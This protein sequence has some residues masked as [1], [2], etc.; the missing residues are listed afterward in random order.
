MTAKQD[1][2]GYFFGR[3]RQLR[4]NNTVATY[5]AEGHKMYLALGRIALRQVD[6]DVPS[7]VPVAGREADQ[8][9]KR[10]Y[11]VEQTVHF[12]VLHRN[13]TKIL[14]G[15]VTALVTVIVTQKR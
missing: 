14:A 8:H 2:Y 1:P 4:T 10:Y 5:S 3:F 12:H 11:T 15:V 13:I 9:T 7:I 6:V